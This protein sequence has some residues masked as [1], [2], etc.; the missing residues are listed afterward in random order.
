MVYQLNPPRRATT[1]LPPLRSQRLRIRHRDRPYR[2]PSSIFVS[3][4]ER[5][6]TPGCRARILLASHQSEPRPALD[7]FTKSTPP[8]PSPH[9]PSSIARRDRSSRFTIPRN[10]SFIERIALSSVRSY[11]GRMRKNGTCTPR[12]SYLP[13]GIRSVMTVVRVC[14]YRH[15]LRT[16]SNY[17]T[18]PTEYSIKHEVVKDVSSNPSP[19][20]SAV[21]KFRFP[22]SA[23]ARRDRVSTASTDF[24]IRA[25]HPTF[26]HTFPFECSNGADGS[27]NVGSLSGVTYSTNPEVG[28]LFETSCYQNS[29]SVSP[30]SESNP[31]GYDRRGSGSTSPPSTWFFPHSSRPNYVSVAYSL[32]LTEVLMMCLVIIAS[33]RHQVAILFY[34]YCM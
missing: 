31:I 30:R 21:Y 25:S 2:P 14:Y 1:Q 5:H 7:P 27:F 12:L 29:G 24:N 3:C 28:H 22:T 8:S 19:I 26:N 32:S 4:R 23:S 16:E 20:F 13:S 11:P 6:T 17:L 33:P 18:D 34:M 15:Q 9:I 10:I